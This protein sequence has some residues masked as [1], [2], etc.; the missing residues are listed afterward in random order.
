M[1]FPQNKKKKV[2]GNI[3]RACQEKPVLVFDR[4]LQKLVSKK[5][6]TKRENNKVPCLRIYDHATFHH[7]LKLSLSK[8]QKKDNYNDGFILYKPSKT[9][10]ENINM[11]LL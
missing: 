7:V 2:E 4:G 8:E 5:Q 1:A 9:N 3:K 11:K 10:N 6:K